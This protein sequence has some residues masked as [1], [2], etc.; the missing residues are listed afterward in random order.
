[1]VVSSAPQLPP[2]P[3][4]PVVKEAL[5]KLLPDEVSLEHFNSQYLQ[6]HSTNGRAILASAKVS[7]LLSSPADQV[8]ASVFANFNPETS[9]DL[10]VFSISEEGIGSADT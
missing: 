9:L 3:I 8:E 5:T 6:K 1:M 10:K 7:R 2:E 4:G